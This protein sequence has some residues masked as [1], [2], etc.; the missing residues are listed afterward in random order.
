MQNKIALSFLVVT[1]GA[2]IAANLAPWD[3]GPTVPGL[4]C[5]R[6]VD[7]E[8]DFADL[9]QAGAKAVTGKSSSVVS[10]CLK[11]ITERC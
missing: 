5:A 8:E 4:T 7:E 9:A 6:V 3:Q 10:S 1:L 11:K 2:A